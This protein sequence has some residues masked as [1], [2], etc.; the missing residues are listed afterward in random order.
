[1]VAAVT[2]LWARTTGPGVSGLSYA[3]YGFRS[4]AGRV[5]LA[6]SLKAPWARLHTLFRASAGSGV[7]AVIVLCFGSAWSQIRRR[8]PSSLAVIAMLAADAAA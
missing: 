1:V 4:A 3:M 7:L 6:H 8:D 2:M 5:V